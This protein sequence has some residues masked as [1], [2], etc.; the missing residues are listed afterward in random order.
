MLRA[1]GSVDVCAGRTGTLDCCKEEV[2]RSCNAY[3]A[4]VMPE[5]EPTMSVTNVTQQLLWAQLMSEAK[6]AKQCK[7]K[8]KK[9]DRLSKKLLDS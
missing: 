3:K 8:L 5:Q 2:L 6:R 1:Q 4:R 9:R 7:K